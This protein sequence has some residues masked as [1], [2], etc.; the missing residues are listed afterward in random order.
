MDGLIPLH[1]IPGNSGLVGSGGV[2]GVINRI[3][4]LPQLYSCP[5]L[6]FCFIQITLNI[7]LKIPCQII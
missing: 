2:K 6:F 4:F 1:P 7:S 5:P 3:S